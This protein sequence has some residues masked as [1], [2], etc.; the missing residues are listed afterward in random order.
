V[1]SIENTSMTNALLIHINKFADLSEEQSEKILSCFVSKK[2][3]KKEYILQAGSVSEH[4]CFIVEG[5]L[6]AFVVDYKGNE[7]TLRF[8]IENSWIGDLDSF[9]KREPATYNIQALE[10]TTAL[11]IRVDKMNELMRTMPEFEH[12]FRIMFQY[13]VMSLQKRLVQDLTLSAEERYTYFTE[14]YPHLLQRVPQKHIASYLGMTPEFLSS[15]R[16][17]ISQK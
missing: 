11:M 12:Y 6:R 13:G 1:A 17:K 3:Q 14:K 7:H 15:L 10:P 9:F 2:Y 8:G 4:E 5:C 16:K